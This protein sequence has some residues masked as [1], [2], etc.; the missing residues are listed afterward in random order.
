MGWGVGWGEGV[1]W[2]GGGCRGPW[3]RGRVPEALRPHPE[4]PGPA[5]RDHSLLSGP[6][7][8][9]EGKGREGREGYLKNLFRVCKVLR[10]HSGSSYFAIW[11]RTRFVVGGVPTPLSELIVYSSPCFNV[12]HS[13]LVDEAQLLRAS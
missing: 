12:L 6:R 2:G 8:R 13:C 11:L 4:G 9:R 1:G 7:C 3:P 5:L 10:S